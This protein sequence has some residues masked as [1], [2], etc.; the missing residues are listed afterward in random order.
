MFWSIMVGGW[1]VVCAESQD[2]SQ[3]S[4]LTE[5]KSGAMCT[6]IDLVQFQYLDIVIDKL[7][8]LLRPEGWIAAFALEH[9]HFQP[10]QL[11]ATIS[12]QGF[13]PL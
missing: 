7:P 13:Y 12:E 9:H 1:P 4:K 11:R 2:I 5:K 10:F 8:D 6:Q 3:R